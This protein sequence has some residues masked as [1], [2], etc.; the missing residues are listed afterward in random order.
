MLTELGQPDLPT[1]RD[2][3]LNERD[4]GD[5]SGLNKD[6]ARAKWGEEQVHI[7]RRSYDI[8]PPGGEACATR[9][10][11]AGPI[12]C[13]RSCRGDCSG[14]RCWWPP[15]ATRCARSSWTLDGLSPEKHVSSVE[16]AHRRAD[17]LPPQCRRH[18]RLH[19]RPGGVISPTYR[20]IMV[21]R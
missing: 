8:Q 18:G 5:L 17:H 14:E 20:S 13:R 6:D 16:L 1:V 3:A 12:T 15:T 19:A 7:W 2:L 9:G 10:S 4:Y 21:E 11:H